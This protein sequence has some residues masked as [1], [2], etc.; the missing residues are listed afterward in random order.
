MENG[1]IFAAQR[2]AISSF[3]AVGVAPASGP[4]C[5]SASA[6]RHR[7]GSRSA[8]LHKAG[9]ARAPAAS[10]GGRPSRRAASATDIAHPSPFFHVQQDLQQQPRGHP[11]PCTACAA[12]ARAASSPHRGDTCHS[13]AGVRRQSRSRPRRCQGR[14]EWWRIGHRCADGAIALNWASRR[15]AGRCISRRLQGHRAGGRARVQETGPGARTSGQ[16]S[17]TGSLDR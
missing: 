4:D 1:V 7:P 5:Q 17:K 9:P 13:G 2:T 16:A 6:W 3:S 15:A 10:L 14:P 8:D 12:S 11:A